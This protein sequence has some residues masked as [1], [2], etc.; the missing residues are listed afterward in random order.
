MKKSTISAKEI[1][2]LCMTNTKNFFIMLILYILFIRQLLSYDGGR[3]FGGSR[4][5]IDK[6]GA[7]QSIL[8]KVKYGGA[9]MLN[10]TAVHSLS[11]S[12][13]GSPFFQVK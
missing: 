3:A 8:K 2:A 11:G 9:V 5:E 10:S 12:M 1:S 7:L 4:S 6:S 13:D